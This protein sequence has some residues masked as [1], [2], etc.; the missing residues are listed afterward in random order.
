M[1][2]LPDHLHSLIRSMTGPEKRY[3]K[4]QFG[5]RTPKGRNDRIALFDAIAAMEYFDLDALLARFDRKRSVGQFTTIKQRLYDAVLRSL[6]AYHAEHSI[7]A[8]LARSLHHVEILH[9]KA[10]YADAERMLTSSKRLAQRHGRSEALLRIARWEERLLERDNYALAVPSTIEAHFQ[11]GQEALATEQERQALWDL[12]SKVFM[13]LYRAGQVRNSDASIKLDDLMTHPLLEP[14]AVQRSA[15]ASF[16]YHHIHGAAAF[17]KGEVALCIDH[18][19]KGLGTLDRE[20][21][22]FIDEPNLAISTLSN[23]IYAKVCVARYTEAFALLNKFRTL[24]ER[25]NMPR[26]EDLDLKLFATTASLELTIH[27]RVGDFEKALDL[28]PM[29]ERGI[30]RHEQHLGAMRKASFY[31]QIAYAQLGAGR[32]DHALRWSN[33]LLDSTHI[34]DSAEIVSFGRM[35]HLMAQI[36]ANDLGI[37]PYALRNTTRFLST[38]KRMHRFEPLLLSM[39]RS[40]MKASNM[41]ARLA[42]YRHFHERL[43]PL[44]HDP[45]EKAVFDHMDP[46]AWVEGKL[47]GRAFAEV[48][49]ERVHRS[50]VAA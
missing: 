5:H 3:F 42:A 27:S 38:R 2:H 16:L 39:V 23:L 9:D 28:L 6:S 11:R 35:L 7:D 50:D 49:K 21:S 43:L 26:T 44:Q 12:K 30:A 14:G 33:R 20:R 13:Q 36:D 4:V 22:K 10:L 15:R 48:V 34:D 45:F 41:E 19:E 31:Y 29:V 37:L 32:P 24:P 47:T 25:W 1:E 40:V 17:S 46:I 8:R 18:L